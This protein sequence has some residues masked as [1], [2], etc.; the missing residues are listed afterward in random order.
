MK[1][2]SLSNIM[3]SVILFHIKQNDIKINGKKWHLILFFRYFLKV[4]QER[5]H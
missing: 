3:L 4:L 1:R 2:K 5:T